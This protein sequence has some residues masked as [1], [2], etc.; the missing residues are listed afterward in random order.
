MTAVGTT[1]YN[2]PFGNVIT[3]AHSVATGPSRS[4][5]DAAHSAATGPSRTSG[6]AQVPP[7]SV[8]TVAIEFAKMMPELF[9]DIDSLTTP[10]ITF[11]IH[12]AMKDLK[13]AKEHD[14]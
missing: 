4:S 5:D 10:Q 9:K 2:E 7:L 14:R 8:P 3:H 6:D 12:E 11:N 1:T 13:R